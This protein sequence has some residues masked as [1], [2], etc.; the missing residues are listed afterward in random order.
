MLDPAPT[1][2]ILYRPGAVTAQQLAAVAGVPV[3]VFEAGGSL[4][5][6]EIAPQ[7]LPSPGVGIRHYAPHARL[8][9]TG[10]TNAELD[11]AL[12][13][14]LQEAHTADAHLIG[15]LLPSD[16]K[17]DPDRLAGGPN[18]VLIERWGRWTAAEDLAASLF[19]GL[20]AL[21]DRG[22]RLILCPLPAPGGVADA[23]RDRLQ[24][25]ARA[26]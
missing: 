22:A 12:R 25:A 18:R 23:I 16:W 14:A 6:P 2:M 13:S 26:K 17:A 24:K 3:H 4:P 19:A 7:A 10:A 8:Q 20:R 1:P 15:V 9:L 11:E 21:D 5:Q